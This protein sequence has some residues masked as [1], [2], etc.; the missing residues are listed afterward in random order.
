MAGLLRERA[1]MGCHFYQPRRTTP[2]SS[3]NASTA[4]PCNPQRHCLSP[5]GRPLDIPLTLRGGTLERADPTT[6]ARGLSVSSSCRFHVPPQHSASRVGL[7]HSNSLDVTGRSS[8]VIARFKPPSRRAI[9][10]D[11]SPGPCRDHLLVVLR[12]TAESGVVNLSSCG[13]VF[14]VVCGH[15]L[16]LHAALVW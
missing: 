11:S 13:L 14:D 10:R 12:F 7:G 6:V 1:S 3:H 8:R 5:T 9:F 16:D 15:D 4:P 2:G